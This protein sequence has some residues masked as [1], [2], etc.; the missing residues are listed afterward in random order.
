LQENSKSDN[1]PLTTPGHNE[2]HDKA[3]NAIGLALLDVSKPKSKE[4]KK[5]G[6]VRKL[7]IRII[8]LF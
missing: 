7:N 3:A 1:Q 8:Y 5:T 6:N 2:Q 4:E